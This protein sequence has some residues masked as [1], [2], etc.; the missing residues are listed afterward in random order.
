MTYTELNALCQL[1]DDPD[2]EVFTNVSERLLTYGHSAIPVLESHWERSLDP[3]QQYRIEDIIHRIQ[4]DTCKTDLRIWIEGGAENL[5][6]GAL[7]IARYQYPDLDAD[8]IRQH[9]ARI[10]AD[11][12]IELNETLTALEQ[13][14]VMNH[15]LYEVHGFSGN[16]QN[17]IA[18]Q[19]SFI[20]TV[21][22][23]KK[24][25][26]LSLGIITVILAQQLDLPV[27]GINL[28]E[29]FT[30]GY[31][32]LSQPDTTAMMF[33][34]N[35]FNRG[36]VFGKNEVLRF[37]KKLNVTPDERIMRPAANLEMIF[38]MTNNL[39]LSYNRAGNPEKAEEIASLQ[40]LFPK[41]QLTS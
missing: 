40:E 12:W 41:R 35:P 36:A 22:E 32:D 33:Y 8:H 15:I 23:S 38:R 26:P 27:V 9:F 16:T 30:L 6:E 1:L 11:I 17:Y 2:S 31:R 13:V 10:R 21:M 24:G 5:L 34:I 19:N 7:I 14:R 20:N 28:P 3:V 18:P 29:H 25:N 39:L 37:L 4:F